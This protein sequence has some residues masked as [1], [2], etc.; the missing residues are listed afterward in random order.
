MERPEIIDGLK[1]AID[2]GYS[3]EIAISSFINAG[4]NRQDVLDSA[5][6]LGGSVLALEPKIQPASQPPQQ[7]TPQHPQQI[8]S[9]IILPQPYQSLQ[10]I[11]T[12]QQIQQPAQPQT[13]QPATFNVTI[14]NQPQVARKRG[15]GMVIFL[16]VILILLVGVLL[17]IIFAGDFVREL[18]AKIGLNL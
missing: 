15:W 8:Q 18:L 13:Q 3:I 1:N 10:S 17:A 5:K 7:Q 12:N 2:R 6:F 16:I 14:Q 4:Y 11:Q 9:P